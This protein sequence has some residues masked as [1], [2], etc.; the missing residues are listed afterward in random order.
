MADLYARQ[1][2]VADARQIYE[3]L[4]QRDPGNDDVRA[5]LELLG[6][7]AAAAAPPADGL[8]SAT[9]PSPASGTSAAKV[10]RLERWLARVRE[11]SRVQ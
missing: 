4:L 2:L 10:A 3:H 11:V 6:G 1:G 8:E 9:A 5:K 7:D